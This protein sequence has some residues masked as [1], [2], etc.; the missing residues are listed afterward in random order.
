MNDQS[1]TSIWKML[2]QPLWEHLFVPM[3]DSIIGTVS[4]AL[5]DKMVS[6]VAILIVL[7]LVAVLVE[8]VAYLK[9]SAIEAHLRATLRLLLHLHPDVVGSVTKIASVLGGD[10]SG[11]KRESTNRDDIFFD[12][13]FAQLPVAIMYADVATKVIQGANN[14]CASLFA[15]EQMIGSHLTD[16]YNSDRFRGDVQSLFQGNTTTTLLRKAEGSE[17]YYEVSSAI[18][19]ERIVISAQE[20]TQTVRY[21]TLIAEEMAKSDA[22]LASILPPSLVKRV[23]NG[24]K[25]ISFAV[26]SASISFIDIVEFTPWCGSLPA[27]TVMSTLNQ[28]FKKFDECLAKGATLTKIK[29]IG[30][31]Y[32]SAGGIFSELN[33]PAVHTKDM[34]SFGLGAI[35]A[36][37]ELNREVDQHLRIRVGVNSGGPIVAG[38]LGIGKPTFEILGPA[39]NMAQQMEHHGVPMQVH[40]SRAVYELVYGDIFQIKERG[41]T[42]INTGTVITYLVTGKTT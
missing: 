12:K 28:L 15:T 2:I 26:Q 9:L 18:C 40:V 35:A 36:I 10:F 17:T 6:T 13:V 33:Q 31:C 37:E 34:V 16:W 11:R 42:Q 29:C 20:V 38:V 8:I 23:Q 1:L 5:D 27:A 14:A 22:L 24:E 41:E 7:L 30:D 3:V 21:N 39:I 32:M 19:P 4:A 25:N